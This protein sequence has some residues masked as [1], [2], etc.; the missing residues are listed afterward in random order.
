[1][2]AY[3]KGEITFIEP[4][5]VWLELNGL[6]YEV[7]I[8]LNTYS[9]IK[10]LKSCHL[11]TW[12][13]VKEDAHTL[14]GFY[15]KSEKH[16]FLQLIG[17]SGVGSSTALMITSSMTVAEIKNAIIS[18]NVKAMQSIKGIGSKT[19]QRIILELKDKLRKEGM[20]SE[21]DIQTVQADNK[22]MDEAVIALTTLGI[23]KSQAEKSVKT[24]IQKEGPEVS[25]EE[26]IKQALKTR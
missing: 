12:L 4:T 20:I 15:D 21:E 22:I 7:R 19:A 16:I 23:M 10:E 25:L 3:L 2:I 11:F 14:F 8:S 6:G 13:Q 24:I 9:A 17:I 18:E 1:M 5:I 26:I